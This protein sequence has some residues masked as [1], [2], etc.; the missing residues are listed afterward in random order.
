MLEGDIEVNAIAL[1]TACGSMLLKPR[2]FASSGGRA[3]AGKQFVA[4]KNALGRAGRDG[5]YAE[6]LP[7]TARYEIR[8]ANPAHPAA[9]NCAGR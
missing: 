8:P 1:N 9:S 6:S 4:G 3:G 7:R 5:R 2:G